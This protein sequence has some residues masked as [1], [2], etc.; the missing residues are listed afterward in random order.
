MK[1][2][3]TFKT[4][5]AYINEAKLE[6][7]DIDIPNITVTFITGPGPDKYYDEA[8]KLNLDKVKSTGDLI[9][10][11]EVFLKELKRVDSDLKYDKIKSIDYSVE[12]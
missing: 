7:S 10:N 4:F 8:V 1:H 9:K 2:I 3:K 6:H 5:E 12:D 11:V